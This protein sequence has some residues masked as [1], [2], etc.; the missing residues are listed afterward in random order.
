MAV[1]LLST[2]WLVGWCSGRRLVYNGTDSEP[3]GW[4][5][6]KPVRQPLAR[7]DLVLFPV[8]A[9]VARLVVERR[10]LP[11]HVPLLKQVGAV[12]GDRVCVD[13]V[14]RIRGEVVGPV[15][16]QDTAGR[17]LPVARSGC[18]TVSPGFVFPVSTS[19]GNSFDARYF[20][21]VSLQGVRAT[22]V[23]LWTTPKTR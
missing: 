17:P 2:L 3:H 8:P 20:G 4:Y 15:L 21:E 1:V 10:W 9:Y 19:L 11:P 22:A 6:T 18:F 5:L 14:L 12:A 13:T 7:G 16:S 23:P